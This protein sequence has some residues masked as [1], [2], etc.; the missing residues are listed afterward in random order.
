MSIAMPPPLGPRRR[1]EPKY[2]P[3]NSTQVA[4]EYK[5]YLTLSDPG[6]HFFTVDNCTFR[7][8]LR[9][10]GPLGIASLIEGCRH[11]A[12]EPIRIGK[13]L[14]RPARNVRLPSFFNFQNTLP[15]A[16]RVNRVI[17]NKIISKPRLLSLSG[18]MKEFIC[19]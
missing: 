14:L 5:I 17:T 15:G 13:Q 6:I 12:R 16:E 11:G 3:V 7:T 1:E 4:I 18:G 19:V 9:T 10:C 8:G 2:I